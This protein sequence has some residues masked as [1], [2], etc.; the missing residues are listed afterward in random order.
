MLAS[1]TLFLSVRWNGLIGSLAGFG[2]WS[3]FLLVH[4]RQAAFDLLALPG[5]D[6]WLTGKVILLA[7]TALLWLVGIPW[8]RRGLATWRLEVS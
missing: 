5:D 7:L 2:L 3:V 1:I 6:F 4:M 8:L